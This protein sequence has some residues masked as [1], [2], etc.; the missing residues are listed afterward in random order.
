M[1]SSI[2]AAATTASLFVLI[3]VT[4]A[5]S[6]AGAEDPIALQRTFADIFQRSG[7]PNLAVAVIREG[8]VVWSGGFGNREAG[9]NTPVDERTIFQA[10]SLSKPVFAVAVLKLAEQ[11]KIDLDRPLIDYLGREKLQKLFLKNPMTD[12]RFAR[13]TARHVLTHTTGLPNWRFFDGRD[14][15]LRFRADPG[16][17]F[18]YSGEGF[19][20]L[21]T[22][23]EAITGQ[24]VDDVARELVFTP[25]GMEDAS[26]VFQ[27]RWGATV[28]F[29]HN[30]AGKPTGRNDQRE[31]N[32]AGS[33]C[34]SL[35]DYS[36]F[37]IALMGGAGLGDAMAAEMVRPQV[38]AGTS[39]G[40]ILRWGLGVGLEIHDGEN[41]LWHWG[42]NGNSKCFFLAR[43][44]TKDAI[45]WFSGSDH[46][47][48]ILDAA[49][50]AVFGDHRAL[51]ASSFLDDYPAF[52]SA[53]MRVL[54]AYFRDGIDVAEKVFRELAAEPGLES[55]INNL[56]YAVMGEKKYAEAIRL[57]HLN[58]D[59]FP[60]SA[61]CWDSLAEAYLTSGDREKAKEYYRKAL[62]VDPAF[63][64]AIAALKRIEEGK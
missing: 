22:A 28:A 59:R 45:I 13:L 47:L 49:I 39:E 34:T 12:E 26:Y 6:N 32:T 21:Q 48:S 33:M 27:E 5:P 2:R 30:A 40:D 24:V 35:R 31:A 52:D 57:F 18:G 64:S 46:G 62:Q 56:G 42:D 41:W 25:L 38:H 55:A 53:G 54:R 17:R 58:A 9:K 29:T 4:V 36:R 19:V 1:S 14:A 15:P 8:K 7:L 11:G 37:V 43:P 3:L 61:N 51:I 23:V 60:A 44:A 63:P 20:M 50:G 16:A 10:A